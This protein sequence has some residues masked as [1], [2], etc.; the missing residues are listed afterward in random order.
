MA[1]PMNGPR[2][3]DPW[4]GLGVGWAIVSTLVAGLLVLGGVGFLLDRVAG[5]DAVFTA[6]GLVLGAGF[7][8]YIVYLRYGRGGE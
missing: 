2:R 8:I 3:D 7:G 5:T 4:A 1:A 6:I